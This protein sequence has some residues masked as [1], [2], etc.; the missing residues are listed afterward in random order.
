[1]SAKTFFEKNIRWLRQAFSRSTAWLKNKYER[2]SL[3]IN[4]G[5]LVGLLVV[6]YL[7]PFI[8][9]SI[10]SGE[11]GVRWRR[12]Y[13]GTDTENVLGEGIQ[14]K[15]PW[16]KIYIYDIRLKTKDEI[17][18]VLTE[19]GLNMAVE[20]TVRFRPNQKHLG[21]LHKNVGPD[22]IRK[23][24]IPEVGAHAREAM[25][26]L[27]PQELYTRKRRLVQ[28]RILERLR[29]TLDVE[30]TPEAPGESFIYLQDVLIRSIQLPQSVEA[31]IEAKLVQK[32]RLLE[33]EY[34]LQKEE[35]EKIRKRIE[36][37]GIQL[38]QSMVTTGISEQFLKWKG[39]NATLELAKSNNSKIVIIG[40]GEGGLPIILG[41]L[42]SPPQYT[43]TTPALTA[44]S[45]ERISG[46]NTDTGDLEPEWSMDKP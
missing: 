24:V 27:R 38:F 32:Q 28:Q 34:R 11:A 26:Q 23:L 15:L 25:S 9:V 36:G 29:K 18:N 8:F 14:L 16:D 20:V 44:P 31:A 19:D 12:L 4:I 10:Y 43:P 42:E 13:G 33:Y 30:Y 7:A 1:M 41:N 21:L 5:L 3:Q 17:F 45:E 35:K 2:F 40:A 37:E 22:Y 39:I 6:V 46:S